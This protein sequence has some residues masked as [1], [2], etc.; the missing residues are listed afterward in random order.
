MLFYLIRKQISL[1]AMLQSLVLYEQDLQFPLFD[2]WFEMTSS[3]FFTTLPRT[4]VGFR[5]LTSANRVLDNFPRFY[6]SP[7]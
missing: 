5:V 6:A 2:P 3:S 1:S 4:D 7:Y